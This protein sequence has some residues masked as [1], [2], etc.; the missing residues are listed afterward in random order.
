MSEE[1]HIKTQQDDTKQCNSAYCFF[2]ISRDDP[3]DIAEIIR[4]QCE[5]KHQTDPQ[6]HILLKDLQQGIITEYSSQG[7]NRRRFSDIKEEILV[8]ALTVMNA[9]NNENER[10]AIKYGYDYAWIKYALARD[11][12]EGYKDFGLCSSPRFVQ[13][14]KEMGFM[15]VCESK[16]LN[17][18]FNN[19]SGNIPCSFTGQEVTALETRR[20][21]AIIA[22][23]IELMNT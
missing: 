4:N 20:R 22:K 8:S 1:K 14:I 13:H 2:T 9:V 7:T 5:E 12:V 3:P 15:N 17:K 18:Y 11:M 10:W 6:C 23:F 16:T 21:N 19:I